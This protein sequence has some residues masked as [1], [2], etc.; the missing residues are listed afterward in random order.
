MA[1]DAYFLYIENKCLIHASKKRFHTDFIDKAKLIDIIHANSNQYILSDL[2]KFTDGLHTISYLQ[3]ID[4]EPNILNTLYFVYSKK[5]NHSST[6]R[7]AYT[8]HRK[9]KRKALKAN[10][11]N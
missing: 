9:T 6:K 1:I 7:I 11:P 4:L 5:L 2:L 3:D 8:T 10:T